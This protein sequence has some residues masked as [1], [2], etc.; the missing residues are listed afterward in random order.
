VSA[1]HKLAPR[2]SRGEQVGGAQEFSLAFL[3]RNASD[4][5]DAPRSIHWHRPTTMR[6]LR[7]RVIDDVQL[8]RSHIWRQRFSRKPAACDDRA[9]GARADR[10]ARPATHAAVR[11]LRWLWQ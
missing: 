8:L 10:R 11:W 4:E 7:R 1:N 9:P 3:R 5:T 6:R 2:Q